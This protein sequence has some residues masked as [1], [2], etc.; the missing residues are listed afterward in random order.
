MRGFLPRDM[1]LKVLFNKRF[2]VIVYKK[3]GA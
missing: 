2:Q 1:P 3:T